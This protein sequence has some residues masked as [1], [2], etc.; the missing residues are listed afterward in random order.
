MRKIRI[1]I[2]ISNVL[3]DFNKQYINIYKKNVDPDFVLDVDLGD[4][5]DIRKYVNFETTTDQRDF[6][7]TDF[8]IDIYGMAQPVTRF[9]FSYLDKWMYE[10]TN[11]EDA[12]Y[13]FSFFG[14]REIPQTIQGTL[15]FLSRIRANINKIIFPKRTEDV[16]NDCDVVITTDRKLIDCCPEGKKVIK[17]ETEYNKD[18]NN[19]FKSY[20]LKEV[21][22]LFRDINIFEELAQ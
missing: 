13:E 9:V 17:V 5:E 16:W 15:F 18:M 20:P 14:L 1:G 11:I 8:P 10:S 7:F 2:E 19:V 6:E 22:N 3:R 21:E 4:I 12:E